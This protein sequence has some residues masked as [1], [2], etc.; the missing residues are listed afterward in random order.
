MT[1]FNNLNHPPLFGFACPPIPEGKYTNPH[2]TSL[3][4]SSKPQGWLGL[5]AFRELL[6]RISSHRAVATGEALTDEKAAY[7]IA[8]ALALRWL[9]VARFIRS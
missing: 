4:G 7:G 5:P 6:C 2:Q 3:L 9:L 8:Y 1:I